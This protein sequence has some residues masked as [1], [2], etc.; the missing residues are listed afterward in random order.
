MSSLSKQLNQ[1][2][3]AEPSLEIGQGEK[4]QAPSLLFSHK[5]SQGR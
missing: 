1:L 2:K 4:I 5:V 3:A